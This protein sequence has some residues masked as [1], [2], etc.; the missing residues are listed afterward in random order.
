MFLDIVLLFT[1]FLHYLNQ[2]IWL[3]ILNK[4]INIFIYIINIF[5]INYKIYLKH[6]RYIL[7]KASSSYFSIVDR[8]FLDSKYFEYF[9]ILVS[10][11]SWLYA[12]NFIKIKKESF[13]IE[14]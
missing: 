4:Y 3:L 14:E 1:D 12:F 8:I 13:S 9:S 2:D 6:I 10:Q 7:W 5:I 11:L